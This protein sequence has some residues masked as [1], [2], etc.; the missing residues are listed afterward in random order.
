MVSSAGNFLSPKN[1]RKAARR[2]GE[3]IG[4]YLNL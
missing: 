4:E 3:K 1:R 2:Q